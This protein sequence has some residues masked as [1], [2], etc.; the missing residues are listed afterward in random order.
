MK[1]NGLI[2][3]PHGTKV[4][5]KNDKLH[6]EN[7]PAIEYSGGTKVWYKNGKLIME[8]EGSVTEA[9]LKMFK[10]KCIQ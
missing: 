2:E 3:Y 6:R 8:S 9:Q 7:G 4:W 5:Y 10:L 1:I